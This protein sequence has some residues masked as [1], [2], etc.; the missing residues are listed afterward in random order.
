MPGMSLSART[1]VVRGPKIPITA[2]TWS[3]PVI[4][5]NLLSPGHTPKMV[6]R[7]KFISTILEPSSGSKATLNPPV[8]IVINYD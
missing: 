5:V 2:A 8:H 1:Y 4:P 7:M 3:L 6:P